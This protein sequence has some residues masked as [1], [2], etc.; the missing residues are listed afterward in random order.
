MGKRL[1]Q[2]SFKNLVLFFWRFEDLIQ[3]SFLRLTDLYWGSSCRRIGTPKILIFC[4]CRVSSFTNFDFDS[5]FQALQTLQLEKLHQNHLTELLDFL[6]LLQEN[7]K[8][9]TQYFVVA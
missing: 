7:L 4:S 5:E 9:E 2:N 1:G 6:N 3:N 8:L